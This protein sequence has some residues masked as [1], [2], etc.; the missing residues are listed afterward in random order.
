[1]KLPDL[2]GGLRTALPPTSK[3]SFPCCMGISPKHL[4]QYTKDD[5]AEGRTHSWN[6]SFNAAIL[7][8]PILALHRYPVKA[9]LSFSNKYCFNFSCLSMSRVWQKLPIFLNIFQLYSGRCLLRDTHFPASPAFKWGYEIK[10]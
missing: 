2:T 4:E 7:P 5:G 3:A 9:I 6:P 1:M 8:D 10:L